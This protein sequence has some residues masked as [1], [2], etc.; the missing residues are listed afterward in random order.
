[1]RVKHRSFPRPRVENRSTIKR[2]KNIC[3]KITVMGEKEKVGTGVLRWPVKFP[4]GGSETGGE[5]RVS[6]VSGGPGW[7]PRGGRTATVSFAFIKTHI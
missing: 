6:C 4:L 1:M 3:I 2:R 5:L 7:R